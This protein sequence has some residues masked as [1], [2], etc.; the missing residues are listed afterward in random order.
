MPTGRPSNYS[1]QLTSAPAAA[2]PA[3]DSSAG[4]STTVPPHAIPDATQPVA[5]IGAKQ[6]QTIRPLIISE[7]SSL[8]RFFKLYEEC[9]SAQPSDEDNPGNNVE[10]EIDKEQPGIHDGS[11]LADDM[12]AL[13]LA[14][15]ASEKMFHVVAFA[16][17]RIQDT[18]TEITFDMAQPDMDPLSKWLNRSTLRLR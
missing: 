16:Q 14:A 9:K 7:S 8:A 3:G 15:Q 18:C 17:G 11:S 12:A 5:S 10:T 13:D 6:S 4:P 2:P 1:L